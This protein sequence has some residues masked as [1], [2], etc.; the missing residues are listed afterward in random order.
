MNLEFAIA[1]E[2]WYALPN[3]CGI[4]SGDKRFARV[5]LVLHRNTLK[6]SRCL[7]NGVAR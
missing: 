7:D 4:C 3:G 1:S 2:S 5:R 6:Q